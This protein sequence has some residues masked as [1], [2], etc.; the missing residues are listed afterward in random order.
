MPEKGKKRGPKPKPWG[1][2]TYRSK[3]LKNYLGREIDFGLVPEQPEADA[4]L[5]NLEP[6][7]DVIRGTRF[8]E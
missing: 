8:P 4:F 1:P 7:T 3:S 5:D 6:E 2:K